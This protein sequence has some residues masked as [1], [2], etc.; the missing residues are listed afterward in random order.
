MENEFL[1]LQN[2]FLP[3]NANPM[4]IT[5]QHV[6]RIKRL[7]D[8][9]QANDF[10]SNNEELQDLPSFAIKYVSVPFLLSLALIS[11]K[12]PS[13]R[14]DAIASAL[15]LIKEFLHLIEYYGFDFKTVDL[16][17]RSEKIQ[18]WQKL[19]EYEKFCFLLDNISTSDEERYREVSINFVKY[20]ILAAQKEMDMIQ[21]EIELLSDKAGSVIPPPTE[22][23]PIK[24]LVLESKKVKLQN[25]FRPGHSLPTMTVQE[26]YDKTYK[27]FNF[28]YANKLPNIQEESD[29]EDDEDLTYRLRAEDEFNDSN[30][31]GSGNRLNR[32]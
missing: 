14:L 10:F 3:G 24:T 8:F 25:V 23:K 11:C 30:P 20:C 6:E 16:K 5:F 28:S 22:K 4:P 18:H 29:S 1:A 13:S 15:A 26:F 19:K 27:D 17:N 32:S 12:S 21:R 31:R 2:L 9:I 7:Y